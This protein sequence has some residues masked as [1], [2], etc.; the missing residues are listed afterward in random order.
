MSDAPIIWLT[1]NEVSELVTLEDAIE[2]LEEGLALEGRGEAQNVAKALGTWGD[3]NSMHALGSMFPGAGYVGFKTWANTRHGAG[4]IFELFNAETGSLMAVIEA[5]LLGQLRTSGISGLATKWM[6]K[7]DASEMALI[8]TGKSALLQV[9]AIA[10]VRP[11]KRLRVYS[12]TEEHR[13]AFVKNAASLL[14]FDVVEA[15]TLREATQGAEI[16]TIMTRAR[17]PFFSAADIDRGAHLNAVGAILPKF[18]EFHQDIFDRAS[19]VVVDHIPN[20]KIASFE[21]RKRYDGG[22]GS[23]D[24]VKEL[25]AII[26]AKTT[27]PAD[28]DITLFK[29]LGMGISDL[30]VAKMV[31]ERARAKG[32]GM[33]IPKPQ[34]VQA[35]W[36]SGRKASAV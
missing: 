3:G 15:A 17:E 23:W 10:A 7:P 18:G 35:R 36:R 31:Y 14:A 22:G 21:F 34:R 9:A 27:R 24:D 32:I 29:A 33:E 28:A 19:M 16:I 30:S 20:A 26:A 25:C 1:G 6:A 13:Q 12:P 11:L 8:G 5:G 2:A 4:T